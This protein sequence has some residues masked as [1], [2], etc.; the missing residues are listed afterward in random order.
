[1]RAGTMPGVQRNISFHVAYDGT[2]FHGWQTQPGQRTVQALLEESIQR[3]VRHPVDLIGSGRTDA[4]VHAVGQVAN[5]RTICPLACDKLQHSIGS[6]LPEDVS[7][8]ATCD[9]HAD[10]H[11]THG[12]ERKLYR[13]RIYN[14][15]HRP[16]ER[17]LQRYTFHFWHPLDEEK[18]REAARRFVGELDFSAMTA[19]GG[20]RESMI[21]SVFRCDVERNSDEIQIDVEGSGFLYRQV[22]NMVGTLINVGRG[23]WAAERVGEILASKD[24]SLAGP[25]AP[26]HGLCLMWV[27][28]PQTLLDPNM[29]QPP[30]NEPVQLHRER[31]EVSNLPNADAAQLR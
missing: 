9:V 7:V 3:V 16:V 22:R 17:F 21:R 23:A 10:F 13:Y 11:A 4:G 30:P 8:F 26:A 27:R 31:N 20:E 5:F 25:T 1:M 18:L 29:N 28:Y 2:D 14:S 6:R 19:A 15:P 24:R 12:A